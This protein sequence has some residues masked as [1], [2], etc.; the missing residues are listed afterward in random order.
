MSL[1]VHR[2]RVLASLI[3]SPQ[4]TAKAEYA[5]RWLSEAL[6]ALAGLGHQF[7]IVPG[8]G[9]ELDEWPR[10]VFH[11]ELAPRGRHCATVWDFWDL[12]PDWFFTHGEAQQASGM[13]AQAAGRGGIFVGGLP[14]PVTD[15][16]VVDHSAG[17]AER[18]KAEFRA[19]R[20][21]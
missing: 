19:S 3:D 17:Y 18:I 15:A 14:A 13:K 8:P 12:G 9:P 20:G 11:L 10:Q 7:H 1:P 2:E 21:T 5:L 6:G 4:A 16:D